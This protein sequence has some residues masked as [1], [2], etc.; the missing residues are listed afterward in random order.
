MQ[1]QHPSSSELKAT[2]APA[3][4][5]ESTFKPTR[6]MLATA[7]IGAAL[8]SYLVHKSP[9]ARQH[10]ASLTNKASRLGDLSDRDAAVVADLLAKPIIPTHIQGEPRYVF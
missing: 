6:R 4:H 2:T 8:I 9:D 3:Q 5:A 7:M 1:A 10:L